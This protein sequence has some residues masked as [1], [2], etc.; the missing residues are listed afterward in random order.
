MA[1]R[2]DALK[3]VGWRIAGIAAGLGIAWFAVQGGEF[4]TSDLIRQYREIARTQRQIDSLNRVIDSL[5][6]YQ[7]RVEH[8]PA[9]QERIAREQFG[10][11][12][13]KELLYRFADSVSKR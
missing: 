6:K 7:A 5:R 4:G 12:R 10:M 11:I 2:A 13:E 3:T 1:S 9:T 8:D